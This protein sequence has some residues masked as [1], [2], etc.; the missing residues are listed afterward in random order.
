M[1][2]V[3]FANLPRVNAE[4]VS[5]VAVAD[6]L[7]HIL[8]KIDLMTDSISMHAARRIAYADRIET[9]SSQTMCAHEN[10]HQYAR[11]W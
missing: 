9:I 8:A 5:Y 11:L 4:D 3:S 10:S 6:K 1:D 2:C 7:A